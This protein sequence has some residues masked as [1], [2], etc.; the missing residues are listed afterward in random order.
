MN[1]LIKYF[2]YLS[3]DK[4]LMQRWNLGQL[5]RP[6]QSLYLSGV[7]GGGVVAF[8]VETV[9]SSVSFTAGGGVLGFSMTFG[10]GS[11][12]VSLT[13]LK[14]KEAI[15]ITLPITIGSESCY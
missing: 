5:R 14:V 2:V 8:A 9:S 1:A 7:V 15:K 3:M 13:T 11:T 6:L 4:V 10:G 12:G